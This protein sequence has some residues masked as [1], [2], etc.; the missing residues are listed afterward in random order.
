MFSYN[1]D[2]PKDEYGVPRCRTAWAE[3]CAMP[4]CYLNG[5]PVYIGNID[6]SWGVAMI[7]G[8]IYADTDEDLTESELEQVEQMFMYED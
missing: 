5:R 4:D 7:D 8:A 6:R 1:E 3:G 2:L